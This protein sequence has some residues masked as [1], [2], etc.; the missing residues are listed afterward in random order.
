MRFLNNY[1]P[2]YWIYKLRCYNGNCHDINWFQKSK[3]HIL[4]TFYSKWMQ[5]Y[6]DWDFQYICW[7]T[8]W[9]MTNV[10]M[11]GAITSWTL[12]FKVLSFIFPLVCATS[13]K[14]HDVD[15]ILLITY[16]HF[17]PKSL[18]G[19]DRHLGFRQMWPCEMQA[20]IGFCYLRFQAIHFQWD[21]LCL[22][23]CMTSMTRLNTT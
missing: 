12:K 18:Q 21:L 23:E 9:I 11:W 3:W 10:T 1:M 6:M 7:P 20:S 19:S 5:R 15:E 13:L 17:F 22:K 8:S 14:K 2:P 16:D 4:I